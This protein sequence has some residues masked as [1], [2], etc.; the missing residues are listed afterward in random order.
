MSPSPLAPARLEVRDIQAPGSEA[1]EPLPRCPDSGGDGG[2]CGSSKRPSV[3]AR[4]STHELV[5]GGYQHN[6]SSTSGGR[7]A[8]TA[9]TAPRATLRQRYSSSTRNR[10]TP[11]LARANR[12]AWVSSDAL[13]SRNSSRH[14]PLRFTNT[15]SCL[16]VMRHGRRRARR[17]MTVQNRGEPA[18]WRRDRQVAISALKSC[19]WGGSHDR[20]RSH[21]SGP[22]TSLGHICRPHSAAVS[23]HTSPTRRRVRG[24]NTL[25]ACRRR[26]VCRS[27]SGT[28]RLGNSTASK[29]PCPLPARCACCWGAAAAPGCAASVPEAV[30][31]LRPRRGI[32]AGTPPCPCRRCRRCAP[33]TL[34]PPCA[35]APVHV[36]CG[37][38]GRASGCGGVVGETWGTARRSPIANWALRGRSHS[39][40][41]LRYAQLSACHAHVTYVTGAC[42]VGG[43][44]GEAWGGKPAVTSNRRQ[45][46][47]RGGGSGGT[48]IESNLWHKPAGG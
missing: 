5:A 43:H 28:R 19:P 15:S 1:R 44:R 9:S 26:R 21:N 7:A 3:A 45:T 13:P 2:C 36:G 24:R 48:E 31:P 8:S 34:S 47:C 22:S 35:L 37:A 40:G 11:M 23:G 6:A 42:Y 32:V 12:P 30:A 4:R 29:L 25:S 38:M 39:P 41:H 20:T 10:D 17:S 27:R 18:S 33:R 46:L 16:S 14:P